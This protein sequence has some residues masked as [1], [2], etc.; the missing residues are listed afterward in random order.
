MEL[1][2]LSSLGSSVVLKSPIKILFSQSVLSRREKRLLKK[3]VDT[4]LLLD[5]AYRQM[6]SK[7]S[8]FNLF[9]MCVALPFTRNDMSESPVQSSFLT[10]VA[11]PSLGALCCYSG[12]RL[13]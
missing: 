13:R 11:T 10:R 7:S 8:S 3:F 6:H 12:R 9:F 5:G 4:V 2:F 1:S